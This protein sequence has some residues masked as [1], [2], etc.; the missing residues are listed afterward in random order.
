MRKRAI[1]RCRGFLEKVRLG[2]VGAKLWR[3]GLKKSFDACETLGDLLEVGDEGEG[4]PATRAGRSAFGVGAQKATTYGAGSILASSQLHADGFPRLIHA[5]QGTLRSHLIFLLLHSEQDSACL[6]LFFSP[7]SSSIIVVV[8]L[9]GTT[10]DAP[11]LCGLAAALAPAPVPFEAANPAAPPAAVGE[12]S[13]EEGEMTIS[14][15]AE[16]WRT[17]CGAAGYEEV[18]CGGR[19]C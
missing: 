4:L 9:T 15:C 1:L 17:G 5:S 14:L 2:R 13:F 3:E 11:L 6:D 19:Y 16:D 10:C 7:P 18:G 12:E 8:R